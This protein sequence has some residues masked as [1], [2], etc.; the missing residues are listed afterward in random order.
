MLINNVRVSVGIIFFSC[1]DALIEYDVCKRLQGSENI[2][3]SLILFDEYQKKKESCHNENRI[4]FF[5][6]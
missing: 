1:V 3:D 2:E 4:I 6:L 5:L